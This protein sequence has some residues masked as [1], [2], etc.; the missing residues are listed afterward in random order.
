MITAPFSHRR[1]LA[2]AL[3]VSL[4]AGT[5]LFWRLSP[6]DAAPEAARPVPV[7][8]VA[9]VRRDLPQT[10]RS[11]G[12]V[13]SL[14]DVTLR[15]RVQ[16][17]LVE[18]LFAE[19]QMVQQGELLARIDDRELKAAVL[20]ARANHASLLAQLHAAEVD[21]E[22]YRRLAQGEALPRQTLE[23]QSARVDELNAQAQAAE[24]AVASAEARLSYTRIVSPLSG[25]VGLRRVDPGN[26][27]Q[28][29]DAEGLVS[30][31]QIDPI[32]V[33]FTLPQ[34]ALSRIRPLLAGPAAAVTVYDR[35]ERT[36]LA[37]GQLTM[38]DNRVDAASGT[39]RLRATFDNAEGRLWP[40][41][42]VGVELQTAVMPQALVVPARAVRQGLHGPFVYRVAGGSAEMVPVK[43]AFQ[44]D[45]VA[46]IAEGLSPG[47]RVVVDG[48]SRLRPGVPVQVIEDSTA[49]SAAAA[50]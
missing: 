2:V 8:V 49:R 27:V 21:L 15:A 11:I 26:L 29:A 42:F 38:V 41:Q 25:R 37:R 13:E 12:T 20:L 10:V 36:P 19:G 24:A 47:N 34:E 9:A 46:A 48:Y 30:V 44:D 31:T 18:V 39:L 1:R 23:R 32:S 17:V 28:P 5:G 50:P 6:P 43:T 40:G 35:S 22:R 33:L 4:L 45:E 7:S 16:G 14:H 3:V